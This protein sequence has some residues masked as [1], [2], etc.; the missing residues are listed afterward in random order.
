MKILV[1]DP[2]AEKGIEILRQLPGA[3]VVVKT[4]L[5]KEELI[6][7]IADCD[8]LVIRS[9]TQVDADVLRA[10]KKLKVVGRAGV[11]VDNVD[12]DAATECGVIVM[13]TPDGNTIST[14]EHAFCLLMALA[15]R[16]PQA[17]H[18]L[19]E[20]RW[21]RKIYKGVELNEKTLGILG[22]GRVGTEVAKRGIAFGMKVIC[23]DPYISMSKAKTL[24]VEVVDKDEL[25]A[26]ADFISVHMPL[27]DETRGMIDSNS[28]SRM[29]K[30]VR[31]VNCARGGIVNEEDLLKA[32]EEGKV[33]GAAF[34]VYDHEPPDFNNPIF[35]NEN[36]VVTPHLGASTTEAQLNVGIQVAENVVEVLRGGAI[37]N[38]VNMPSLDAKTMEA[39]GPFITL[40]R[41]LGSL[42][43]VLAPQ[44]IETLEITYAGRLADSETSP[45]T[46]SILV[47]ILRRGLGDSVNIVNALNKA[48]E[49]GVDV[50][51]RKNHEPGV[52]SELIKI[53]AKANGS[54]F[55][56]SGTMYTPNRPR[57][58]RINGLPVEAEP[59]GTLLVVFNEDRP[60]VIGYI[61]KLLGDLGINIAGMTCGRTEAGSTATTLVNIDSAPSE[62]AM[63][64]LAEMP[65]I[66]RVEVVTF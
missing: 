13:N 56:V 65:L 44:R 26:R 47:G 38:A 57:I 23:Y 28:I 14:A 60:G 2:L 29:K 33:A 22:M 16:V 40:G 36:I 37:R 41:T 35:H 53:T 6:S 55:S 31:I 58:V 30:G 19:H 3:Q 24:A 5:P 64:K 51:E 27:T 42:L 46:R 7:E 34:D 62:E 21:D 50:Q 25:F 48:S 20:G 63:A 1:S 52:F 59:T 43:G 12:L 39:V 32:L 4:G 61:G 9:G 10:G 18:S 66:K 54:E 15:R 17:H 11:G 8:A 45:V 49:Q